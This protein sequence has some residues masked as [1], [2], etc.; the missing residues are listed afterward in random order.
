[1]DHI[2]NFEKGMNKDVSPVYQPEGTYVDAVNIEII[3]DELQGS[4]AISNSKGNKFQITIPTPP[5]IIKVTIVGT[6]T[7][8]I[9]IN[10]E[11]S[12][13]GF[14]P[15]VGS[16]P[17]DLYD[18]IANDP[19][20]TGLGVDY[21]IYYGGTF[22][23]IIPIG[24]A[25]LTVTTTVDLATSV[26]IPNTGMG[27]Q[28]VIGYKAIRD[29]IYLL[30]TNCKDTDPIANGGGYGFFWKLTY[31][32]ITFDSA[33]ANITLLYGAD[34]GFST[35][36]H[37]PQTGLIGLY[38]NPTIQR[39]YFTD[40]YNKLRSI[41]LVDPQLFALD[42]LL[43]NITPAVDFDIPILQNIY[44]GSGGSIP[45]GAYQLAY[46]LK[47]DNG[48]LTNFSELS[49]IV[50]VV[51]ADENS[52][53]GGAGFANYI[54][55]N[56]GTNVAKTIKWEI[57]NLDIDYDRI[58]IA[59][60]F[61]DS[62]TDPG[63]CYIIADDPLNGVD[64]YTATYDGTQTTTD[65]TLED[66]LALSGVFTHCK[67][68][69]T[70]DNRLFVGNVRNELTDLDF[71]ARAYRW[72]HTI[73]PPVT[74]FK[75]K[76]GGVVNTYSSTAPGVVA[77]DSDA[78]A[79]FNL[80]PSDPDYDAAY[81]HTTTGVIGGEGEN[82][83]YEFYTIAVRGDSTYD[84]VTSTPF[85]IENITPA[86]WVHTNPEYAISDL[87]VGVNSVTN[88]NTSDPQYHTVKITS[89][90]LN[91]NDNMKYPPY[92][93]LYTGYQ[94]DEI[95]RFGIQFYDRSKNPYFVKW[96]GDIKMPSQEDTCGKSFFEDGTATGITD[97]R[98]VFTYNKTG[99]DECFVL[100]LGI[101]FTV[102]I[103]AN[104]TDKISG[105]SIVRV[106]RE[107]QDKT[108]VCQGYINPVEEHGGE[109]YIINPS[110]DPAGSDTSP[111]YK[112]RGF[113][114]SPI[115]Y[116]H[117][118]TQPNTGCKLVY[119]RVI[120]IVNS[121]QT[122][123]GLSGDTYYY[124]KYFESNP[125]GFL[126]TN[127]YTLDIVAELSAVGEYLGDTGGQVNNYDYETVNTSNSVGNPAYYF[128]STSSLTWGNNTTTDRYLVNFERT[129]S[130]QY[131]GNTFSNRSL[132]LYISCSHFRP[133]RA[134]GIDILDN[135]QVFGGDTTVQI[136]DSFRQPK[137][138]AQGGRGIGTTPQGIVMF[139]PIESTINTGLI[140][141]NRFNRNFT[142]DGSWD[143]LEQLIYNSSYSCVNNVKTYIPKPDPYNPTEI[144][145]TR[146]YASE[147]KINGELV[148]SWGRFK[149]NNYWDVEGIY[150]PIVSM[151]PLRDK[152]YFWQDKSFG[153]LQ[154][155]P[156]A[157]VTDVNATTN[158]QLQLGTGLPLQRHDYLSTVVG[159]KSQDS[160][161]ASSYKLYWYDTNARKIYTFAPDSSTNPFSDVKGMFSYLN[162]YLNTE[163]QN[164]DKHCYLDT[165]KGINGVVATYDYKR[166]T[167]LFTFHT[168]VNTG[169][170]SYD[171]KSFTL[172]LNERNDSF[173]TFYSFV[174]RMY[175]NDGKFV[176]STDN[177]TAAEA[178]LSDIYIHRVGPYGEFYGTKYPSY[179]K[180]IANPSPTFTKV[181]DNLVWDSQ[182]T[183]YDEV[184]DSYVNYND[185]TWNSIRVTDDYQNTDTQSLVVDSNIK[186]K[187]R[188]WQL[189]IP[190]NRV[191]YTA[192]DSPNI[193]TDLSPTEK[194]FG[195]RMRD[196]YIQVELTYNNTTDTE[197]KT[198]S[199]KTQFR[200]SAR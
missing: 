173:T 15:T 50:Y 190:R 68:I 78:I 45:V 167:A 191:L 25:T 182:A 151:L 179:I 12:A 181:F 140:N 63:T 22:I 80:D 70:K 126:S 11:V 102:N 186:R 105:Y 61:R 138:M 57:R 159:T 177:N 150:G 59:I 53:V 54:G 58:E 136:W 176:F 18:F 48:A 56:R 28:Q 49:D 7:S 104:L 21:N 141:G 86:P 60:V 42:P 52:N 148:D 67:T 88:L 3:D 97:F 9:T 31:D 121:D 183:I 145:D 87:Y 160:T 172:A 82:I 154:I 81:K 169:E 69:G 4:V 1:M 13:G 84:T 90:G 117:A 142:D 193:Y 146:F 75:I 133:V 108:I 91:I 2:Q 103:P 194:E 46:R 129:L 24:T 196:K 162:K 128:R 76:E 101:D 163:I 114:I 98:T 180:F 33:S 168:G 5:T 189:D 175:L 8:N 55:N 171:Q 192:S 19:A 65:L 26:I 93:G 64:T 195:E 40:N 156:R 62:Y 85:N 74:N 131:G 187:E 134:T 96:I 83:K 100:Q 41:N 178:G 30:T 165:D 89:T 6:S 153:V 35:Y 23:S 71:D 72:K 170:A 36:Y 47:N 92:A 144:F 17:Q 119:K 66:F 132:N 39:I 38:E 157:V 34:L 185:V 124:W 20:Y 164:I 123:I 73:V 111:F 77:E 116:Q 152:M 137:C 106:N 37:F 14:T 115:I 109:F 10:G 155:N 16:N 184:T 127:K 107:E 27:G 125:G 199:I 158:N 29:D 113:F 161:I 139:L 110:T 197:L 143:E 149:T 118:F 43:L 51:G 200:P 79:V 112:Q 174:P 166:H 99:V 44:N 32:N 198:N 147:I 188:N 120:S 135:F 94:R 122:Y 95:Y 130:S